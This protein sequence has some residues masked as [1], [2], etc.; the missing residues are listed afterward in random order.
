MCL[1]KIYIFINIYMQIL[2]GQSHYGQYK[3][4]ITD[5]EKI[6]VKYMISG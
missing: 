6:L 1:C 4:K 3:K 5:Q 2:K